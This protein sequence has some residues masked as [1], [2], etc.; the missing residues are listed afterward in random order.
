MNTK[1]IYFLVILAGS[2]SAASLTHAEAS[3]SDAAISN[4]TQNPFTGFHATGAVGFGHISA[5]TKTT[6]STPTGLTTHMGNYRS[7]ANGISF[8]AAGDYVWEC[9]EYLLGLELG[10]T[11]H[12]NKTRHDSAHRNTAGV[13][14]LRETVKYKYNL[15]SRAK[16]GKKINESMAVFAGLGVSRGSFEYIAHSDGNKSKKKFDLWGITPSAS[17]CVKLSDKTL[18]SVRYT[19]TFYQSQKIANLPS[20][21]SSI[22]GKIKPQSSSVRIGLTYKF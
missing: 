17:I 6:L 21:R 8:S 7:T 5:K 13:T 11:Y 4:N 22:N 15:A 10:G 18:L 14:D 12:T 16:V 1:K 3:Y 19:H 2:V 20:G 9:Q